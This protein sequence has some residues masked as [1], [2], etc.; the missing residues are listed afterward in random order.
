MGT[1]SW[2]PDICRSLA[3]LLR[4]WSKATAEKL[5]VM[6]STMG[7]RPT[8]AAPM[9]TPVNPLSVMGVSMTRRGPKRSSMPSE[10]L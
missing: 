7:R 8:M 4:I 5:K 9:E 6:Y 3:A 2:P 1:L 10:T